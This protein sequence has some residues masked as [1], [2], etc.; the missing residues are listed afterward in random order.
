MSLWLVLLLIFLF[1]RISSHRNEVVSQNK[2]VIVQASLYQNST[3]VQPSQEPTVEDISRLSIISYSKLHNYDYLHLVFNESLFEFHGLSTRWIKVFALK[4][5]M[6]EMNYDW[7]CYLDNQIIIMDIH[8]SLETKLLEWNENA[9]VFFPENIYYDNRSAIPNIDSKIQIWKNTG[10]TRDIIHRWYISPQDHSQA[11]ELKLKNSIETI[12]FHVLVRS[13]LD[14]RNMFHR[15][16]CHELLGMGKLFEI[17][18]EWNDSFIIVNKEHILFQCAGNFMT[19]IPSDIY[20]L[21]QSYILQYVHQQTLLVLYHDLSSSMKSENSVGSRIQ[22]ISLSFHDFNYVQSWATLSTDVVNENH[23]IL[24]LHVRSHVASDVFSI[25]ESCREHQVISSDCQQAMQAMNHKLTIVRT[26]YE[27]A[28]GNTIIKHLDQY[29]K[30]LQQQQINNHQNRQLLLLLDCSSIY[31][32]HEISKIIITIF[33]GRKSRLEILMKYLYLALDLNLIQEVHIWDYVRNHEEDRIY[34]MNIINPTRGIF[35]KTK[36]TNRKY[37]LDYYEYYAEYAI[38]HPKDIIIKCDDDIVFIDLIRWK[39][40][41]HYLR[42]FQEEENDS[43]NNDNNDD[44]NG[45]HGLLFPNIINNGVAAYYQQKIFG[46]LPN[47]TNHHHHDDLSTCTTSS[48]ELCNEEFEMPIGGLCGSLW[49]SAVKARKVHEYFLNHWQRLTHHHLDDDQE[50][51]EEEK[52]IN[53]KKRLYQPDSIQ[54][55]SRFSIN[56]FAIQAKYWY[57]I[58]DIGEDDEYHSTVTLVKHQKMKNYLY[59]NMLVSHFSFGSQNKPAL[60]IDNLLERYHQLYDDYI[61]LMMKKDSTIREKI[62]K[63][64][65]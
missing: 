29:E 32:Q 49:Q 23:E 45:I 6:N 18:N 14:N 27:Q 65:N 2:I 57:K 15:I 19:E 16:S 39:E 3:T 61:Q 36:Y 59:A 55:T 47:R 35:L 52:D 12:F 41:I 9:W 33:A 11:E 26:N 38:Q 17:I 34:I 5:V 21:L 58:R 4:W 7:V 25:Q 60:D 30:C 22:T 63:L 62:E 8:T 54:I 48:E 13:L 42:T 51:E 10:Y 56:F 50:E 44:N 64:K 46:I 37:W 20:P 28:A 24:T 43:N 53:M 40:Y 31:Y 1:G